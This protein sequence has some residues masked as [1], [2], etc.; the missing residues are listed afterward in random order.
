M[1][2][3][4]LA[5]KQIANVIG[6]KYLSTLFPHPT[7]AAPFIIFFENQICYPFDLFH[8]IPMPQY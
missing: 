4:R 8:P 2:R 5:L 3:L 1:K 6:L 7:I